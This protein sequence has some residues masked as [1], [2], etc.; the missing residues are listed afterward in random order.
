[1]NW[2]IRI[3]ILYTAFIGMILTLVGLTM[4]Q[5]VDLVSKDYYEQELKYQDRIDRINHTAALEQQL[6]WRITDSMLRIQFPRSTGAVSQGAIVF[7]R[8]SDV[9]CDTSINIHHDPSF[10]QS[11]PLQQFTKGYYK[12]Q[13]TW[14]APGGTFYNE[15][16]VRI[17]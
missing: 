5:K 15:G 8:P 16:V 3:I 14:N 10:M 4:R 9:S 13:V 7:F 12:M 11:I 2:G 17:Q 1:M 6:T